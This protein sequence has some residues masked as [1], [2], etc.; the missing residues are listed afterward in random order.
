MNGPNFTGPFLHAR[1]SA[2][3]RSQLAYRHL[4]TEQIQCNDEEATLRVMREALSMLVH[5]LSRG[6]L[7]WQ[8]QCFI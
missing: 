7:M 1:V 3:A 8:A 6:R 5:S 2:H 4:N